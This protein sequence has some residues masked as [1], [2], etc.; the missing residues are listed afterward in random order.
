M[1]LCLASLKEDA[2][3]QVAKSVPEIVRSYTSV[4]KAIQGLIA[5]MQPDWTDVAFS[6]QERELRGHG[7]L[8]SV[9]EVADALRDGLEELVLGFGE[10]ADQLGLSKMDMREAREVIG[11]GGGEMVQR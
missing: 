4:L 9:K 1:G 7:E 3:G 5:T 10:Y 6:G 8:A 11:K 2:Y